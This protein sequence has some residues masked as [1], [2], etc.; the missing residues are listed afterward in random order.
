M[1]ILQDNGDIKTVDLVSK[2]TPPTLTGIKELDKV[3]ISSY[4]SDITARIKDIGLLL[5]NGKITREEA[6]KELNQLVAM[7]NAVS[8]GKKKTISDAQLLSAYKKALEAAYAP[9]KKTSPSISSSIKP[10]QLKKNVIKPLR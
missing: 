6:I 3:K 1:L 10:V 8:T 5:D 4:K 7:K 9:S 2:I